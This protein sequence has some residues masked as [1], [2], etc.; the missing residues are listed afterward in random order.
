MIA[1]LRQTWSGRTP[2]ERL[3][4]AVMAAAV[5]VFAVWLLV[6]RP[7]GV[8]AETAALR[9][10]GA[11]TALTRLRAAPPVPA[12]PADLE[13]VL[14]ASATAQGLEPVLAMSEDGGLGFRLTARDGGAVLRW[15]TAVK[16]ASGVEPMRL[17]ILAEDGTL[18]IDGA[19]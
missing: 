8:W 18:T 11:E 2:R 15:L 1:R 14:R 13:S 5:A 10:A 3:M 16:A 7:L 4:L 19:Y 9:R 12:R 6:L 17:S